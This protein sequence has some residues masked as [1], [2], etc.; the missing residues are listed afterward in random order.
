MC[1]VRPNSFDLQLSPVAGSATVPASLGDPGFCALLPRSGLVFKFTA[2]PHF[3]R[4]CSSVLSG[5]SP[6]FSLSPFPPLVS[7]SSCFV[8]SAFRPS[9]PSFLPCFLFSVLFF[10]PSSPLSPPP[11][12]SLR[13]PSASDT[14]RFDFL[15]FTLSLFALLSFSLFFS[16]EARRKGSR[17]W[18]RAGDRSR[19]GESCGL[20]SAEREH[21][22]PASLL[23]DLPRS[24]LAPLEPG[25]L[26]EEE[27]LCF[28]A[29]S[30]DEGSEPSVLM[31]LFPLACPFFLVVT[32]KPLCFLEV[33]PSFLASDAG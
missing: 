33:F 12:T 3:V 31:E 19:A 8:S 30:L 7:S 21:G 4:S 10:L 20:G 32:T 2:S 23:P 13:A 16:S 14:F 28:P 9:F 25:G 24:L 17:F 29:L 26:T 27:L 11:L 18:S 6:S 5:L 1:L 22:E 15:S